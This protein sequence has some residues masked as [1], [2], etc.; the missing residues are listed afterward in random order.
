MSTHVEADPKILRTK[1]LKANALFALRAYSFYDKKNNQRKIS[2]KD[3]SNRQLASLAKDLNKDNVSKSLSVLKSKNIIREEGEYY[4]LNE[5]DGGYFNIDTD[6]L[7]ELLYKR[8]S[9]YVNIY[10]WLRNRFFY[11]C[12]EG[13]PAYF[14]IKDILEHVFQ[15]K[16]RDMRVYNRIKN[17]L[18]DIVAD[19]L[20]TYKIMRVNEN[21]YLREI[22]AIREE[23]V[24]AEAA[25]EQ[26]DKVFIDASKE[27]STDD[28]GEASEAQ[29]VATVG[30]DLGQVSRIRMDN[31]K[32][33]YTE[34]E[35]IKEY[36]LK[37]NI[38]EGKQSLVD[39]VEKT[40]DNQKALAA[41]GLL[42]IFANYGWKM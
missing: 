16:T 18:A 25:K 19:G 11:R 29:E 39:S 22:F 23:F 35:K 5:I 31:G 41:A 12:K 4:I 13:R 17:I 7:K 32:F 15:Y 24:I 36:M 34:I 20:V 14:S 1:G 9:D 33:E 37:K 40:P 38:E 26:D 42:S 27:K 28:I 3:A 2:R 10:L 30:F 21:L 8:N 6:F